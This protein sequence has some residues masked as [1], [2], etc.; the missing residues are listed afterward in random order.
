MKKIKYEKRLWYE[1]K[2]EKNKI[3]KKNMIAQAI[4]R[5]IKH[6]ESYKP[7]DYEKFKL[8]VTNQ[9]INHMTMKNLSCS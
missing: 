7:Y 5:V 3:W 9:P 4:K 8:F 6:K 2:Y 1:I